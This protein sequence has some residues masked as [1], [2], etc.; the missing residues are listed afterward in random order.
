MTIN[1][2]PRALLRAWAEYAKFGRLKG[3]LPSGWIDDDDEIRRINLGSVDVG[4]WIYTWAERFWRDRPERSTVIAWCWEGL[5]SPDSLVAVVMAVDEFV[6]WAEANPIPTPAEDDDDGEEAG[7]R[8][9]RARK[10]NAED[11]AELLGIAVQSVR[12]LFGRS[13]IPSWH[14]ER[15][16]WVTTLGDVTDYREK[17]RP[18]GPKKK[19]A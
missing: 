5:E 3:V 16:E 17:R 19:V 10:L 6:E 4:A 1:R 11:A 9:A 8:H 15:G 14:D 12:E 13:R 7:E 2:K 18:R